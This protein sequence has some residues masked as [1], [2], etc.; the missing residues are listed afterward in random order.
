MMIKTVTWL[1]FIDKVFI[2][3]LLRR[4]DRREQAQNELN[5]YNIPFDFWTAIEKENGAE[6]LYE[7]MV[8]LFQH[9]IASGNKV[10]G[11]IMFIVFPKP[12]VFV[13]ADNCFIRIW[14]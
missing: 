12:T 4:T 11:I 9:C 2:I 5:S 1:S 13:R 3:N 8:A 6:G 14:I 10:F 7:T